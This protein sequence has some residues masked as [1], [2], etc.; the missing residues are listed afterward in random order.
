[1][2]YCPHIL[3]YIKGHYINAY[4]RIRFLWQSPPS[5]LH[6]GCGMQRKPEYLNIDLSPAVIPDVIAHCHRLGFIQTNSIER[7]ESFHLFEH[8]FP[9]D[10]QATLD[11]WH[12]VLKNDGELHIETPDLEQCIKS[13]GK[14]HSPDGYDLA[15]IGIYGYPPD[16]KKDGYPQ[17]H[18]WGHSFESLKAQLLQTGFSNVQRG[19]IVQDWRLATK[20][21]RDMHIIAT[22]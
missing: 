2:S 21:N 10:I 5:K 7:I 15:M 4:N 22:K 1:M 12:R 8:I 3:K 14:M 17:A 9:D 16:I 6:I 11:E 20:I 18:K 13:I 19:P